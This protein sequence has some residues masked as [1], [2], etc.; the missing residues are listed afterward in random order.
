[1]PSEASEQRPGFSDLLAEL[2]DSDV[3]IEVVAGGGARRPPE[4]G[5]AQRFKEAIESSYRALAGPASTPIEPVAVLEEVA[6]RSVSLW[7]RVRTGGEN[8]ASLLKFLARGTLAIVAW[9][10]GSSTHR[11]ADL[12]Q[13]IRGLPRGTSGTTS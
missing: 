10:D 12:P 8:E 2:T 13:A 5:Q 3:V 11:L 1:M 4:I 9:M 6:R 7:L